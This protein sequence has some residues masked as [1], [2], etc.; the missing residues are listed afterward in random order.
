MP[1]GHWRSP[2]CIQPRPT[3]PLPS[4]WTPGQ[5]TP[6]LPHPQRPERQRHRTATH[7]QRAAPA[8]RL[9]ATCRVSAPCSRAGGR[10]ARA[11]PPARAL[12]RHGGAPRSAI[13]KVVGPSAAPSV[14]TLSFVLMWYGLN[15][16]FNLLNKTIFNYFPFPYTVSAVHV[17]VGLAYCTLTYLFG[18]KKASFGRARARI[19]ARLP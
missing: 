12:R 10:T 17:V 7:P 11:A 5:R 3:L 13:G 18:A 9:R 6:G 4:G 2:G 1:V 19:W 15:V 8:L 16:A 14:V